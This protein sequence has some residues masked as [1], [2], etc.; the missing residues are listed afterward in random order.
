MQQQAIT[1]PKQNSVIINYDSDVDYTYGTSMAI[2]LLVIGISLTVGVLIYYMINL[3]YINRKFKW[4]HLKYKRNTSNDVENDY[5]VN[6]L[7][8]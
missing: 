6:G 3:K 4:P 2:A 7:Y 1:T 8:L 5:F